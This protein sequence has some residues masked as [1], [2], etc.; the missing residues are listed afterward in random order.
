ML[1]WIAQ[2]QRGVGKNAGRQVHECGSSLERT[3]RRDSEDCIRHVWPIPRLD[4]SG[5][6]RSVIRNLLPLS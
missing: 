5:A 1:L 2:G 6:D 3:I 4:G